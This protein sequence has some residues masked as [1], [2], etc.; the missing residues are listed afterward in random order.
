V[1]ITWKVKV[2]NEEIRMKNELLILEIIVKEKRLRWLGHV[3]R[4]PCQAIQWE[5]G[6]KRK[7]G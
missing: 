2:R 4:I 5:L 3:L 6:Y 7:P 1:R